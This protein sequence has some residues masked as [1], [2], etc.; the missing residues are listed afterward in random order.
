[1]P[2]SLFLDGDAFP[3]ALKPILLRAI[4]RHSLQT[5]VISNKAINIGQSDLIFYIIVDLGADQADHR[6]VDMIREGDLLLTSDIPLA[7]RVVSKGA[8][9]IDFRGD[10]FDEDS[11]KQILAIRNLKSDI[12]AE[13][14]ILKGSKPFSKKDSNR[15]ANQLDKYLVK[16]NR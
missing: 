10:L 7:D 3:N 11:I 5:F 16:H 13:G 14:Q 4:E 15:F 1:M 6:I 12:R 2:L 8:Q 9:A